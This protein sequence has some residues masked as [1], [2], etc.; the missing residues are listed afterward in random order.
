VA[1][2]NVET[3]NPPNPLYKALNGTGPV[4]IDPR[5]LEAAEAAVTGLESDYRDWA[6]QD[7]DALRSL[8]ETVR[9]APG[10]A[11]AML[12]EIYRHALD[13]KGQGGGFGYDLITAIGDLL[14]KF[15]DGKIALAPRDHEIVNAHIDAMQAVIRGD[16]KGNGGKVGNE[17]VTGLRAIVLKPS[18]G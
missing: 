2:P 17:I 15:I 14:T 6:Q 4:K 18:A 16:I 5:V 12:K 1:K 9:A 13:M 11:E 8:V 7:I 10:E 3:F